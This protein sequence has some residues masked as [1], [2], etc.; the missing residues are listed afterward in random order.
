[1]TKKALLEM[2]EVHVSQIREHVDSV[3]IFCTMENDDGTG[4]THRVEVGAGNAFAQTGQVAEW[5]LMEEER[6]R[7]SVRRQMDE[8]EDEDE[9]E[10]C[11]V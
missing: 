9:D 11:G 10:N 3:V 5:L 2:I 6:A 7:Q 1:M 8:E 4:T